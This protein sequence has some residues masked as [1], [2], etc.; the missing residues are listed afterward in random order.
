MKKYLLELYF[1][2][3]VAN[4][5]KSLQDIQSQKVKLKSESLKI[6]NS[7]FKQYNKNIDLLHQYSSKTQNL[8]YSIKNIYF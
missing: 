2:N 4:K 8:N 5:I 7:T 1:P 6:Y 3:L